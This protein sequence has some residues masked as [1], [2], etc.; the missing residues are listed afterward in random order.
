[1]IEFHAKG[2]S[3]G[4]RSAAQMTCRVGLC[5]TKSGQIYLGFFQSDCLNLHR[6]DGA[7]SPTVRC[8]LIASC[9]T[10]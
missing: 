5:C 1:M 10:S 6:N 3:F 4:E 8:R 9:S 7:V 2:N